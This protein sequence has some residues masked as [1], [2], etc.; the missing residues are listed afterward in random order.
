MKLYITSN[1]SLVLDCIDRKDGIKKY[2]SILQQENK[3]IPSN[4]FVSEK[5]FR[6]CDDKETKL[7]DLSSRGVR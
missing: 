5:G 1:N 7:I 2:I 6:W 3:K 4:I